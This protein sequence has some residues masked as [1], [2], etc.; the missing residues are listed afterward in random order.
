MNF[1]LNLL[2]GGT[3]R[4]EVDDC[5]SVSSLKSCLTVDSH[6]TSRTALYK[7]LNVKER[8]TDDIII[9]EECSEDDAIMI[10]RN[11]H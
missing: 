6:K 9:E 8:P 10:T 4:E 2:E 7:R 5:S 1:K 11:M 3:Q